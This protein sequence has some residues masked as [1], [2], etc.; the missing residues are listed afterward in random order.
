VTGVVEGSPEHVRGRWGLLLLICLFSGLLFAGSLWLMM[1]WRPWD[2]RVSEAQARAAVVTEF[3]R[4]QAVRCERSEVEDDGTLPGLGDVDYECL[5]GP[6][7][8]FP[9][10][11]V[12]SDST[13]VT[14][15]YPYGGP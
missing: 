8:G 14:S 4:G 7:Q 1:V 9:V 11:L 6:G 2:P 13:R 3:A 10:V 15:M 5:V 12:G